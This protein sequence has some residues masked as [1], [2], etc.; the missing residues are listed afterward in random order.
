[1]PN[2][3]T[4][5]IRTKEALDDNIIEISDTGVGIPNHVIQH[6]FEP[7]VTT[8]EA[9]R[10]LGLSVCYGIIKRHKGHIEVDAIPNS[11]TVFKIFFPK[12]VAKLT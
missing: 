8:K 2:G 1:M 11:G 10:G 5:Y 6:C 9:G 4:I 12:P 3:G 7:Y